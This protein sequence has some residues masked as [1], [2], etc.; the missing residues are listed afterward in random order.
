[1]AVQGDGDRGWSMA[2]PHHAGGARHAR[3]RLA[4]ELDRLVPPSLRADAVA[5]AAELLGNAVRHAAP[6]PGNVIRLGCRIHVDD[7][8]TVV[9]LRVNDGGSALVPR[10][11]APEPDSPDG[12]GLAIVAALA[13]SWGVE[14]SAAG[15]CVWAQLLG[16]AD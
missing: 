15:Q 9:E 11:R 8:G 16:P 14:R 3:Q 6:L 13:R 10:E 2:V 4:A 12:R 7:S 5:V 1:M